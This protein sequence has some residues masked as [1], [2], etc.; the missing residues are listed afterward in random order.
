MNSV[1][2]EL[3]LSSEHKLSTEHELTSE[4]ELSSE[5]RILLTHCSMNSVF[6]RFFEIKPCL[7]IHRRSP[8]RKYFSRSLLILNSKFM[9]NIAPGPR[10]A[11][12]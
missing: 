11:A 12:K 1:Q 7:Q 4:D 10:Y 6:R 3:E 9:P 2:A 5:H 8:H